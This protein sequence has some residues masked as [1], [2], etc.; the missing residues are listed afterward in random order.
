MN[1]FGT[2]TVPYKETISVLLDGHPDVAG[3]IDDE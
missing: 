1:I 3:G 2:K